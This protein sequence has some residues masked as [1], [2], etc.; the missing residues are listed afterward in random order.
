MRTIIRKLSKPAEFCLVLFVCYWWALIVNMVSIANHLQGIT[1]TG[2]VT[3]GGVLSHFIL[4]FIVELLGL[5]VTFWILRTRGWSLA[6]WGF[7]PS[8]K[9]TGAGVLVCLAAYSVIV[10]GATFANVIHPGI[11]RSHLPVVRHLSLPFLPFL[12]LHAASNSFFEE[13]LETGYFVQSLQRYGMWSAVLAGA[14][15]RAFLHT[16]YLSFYVVVVNFAIGLIFGLIY[17]NWR[18]L[19]PLF[20]AHAMLDFY[21]LFPHAAS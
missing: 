19:W 3:D 16:L 7:Q 13:T 18:K 4:L 8:W 14:L 12:V 6:T 1:R 5:A 17:W 10:T 15:F 21:A 2:K 11:V 9:S 20:I